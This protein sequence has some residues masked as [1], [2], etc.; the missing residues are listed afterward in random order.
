[1]FLK[2]KLCQQSPA[3]GVDPTSLRFHYDASGLLWLKAVDV[4]GSI[5]A[6]RVEEPC[7]EPSHVNGCFDFG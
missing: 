6:L 3:L 2:E 5:I 1:M 4:R 7:M